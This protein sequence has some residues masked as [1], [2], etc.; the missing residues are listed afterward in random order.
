[1]LPVYKNINLWLGNRKIKITAKKK[2]K[3]ILIT[4]WVGEAYNKLVGNDY[5]NSSFEKT[6]CLIT[7]DSSEDSNV[8]SGNNHMMYGS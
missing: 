7:A 8:E 5:S 1:M 6:E 2:K 3:R 4:H